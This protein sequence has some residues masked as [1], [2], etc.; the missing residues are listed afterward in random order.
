MNN[1]RATSSDSNRSSDSFSRSKEENVQAYVQE[2]RREVEAKFSASKVNNAYTFPRK[3]RGHP[4]KSESKGSFDSL[5]NVAFYDLESQNVKHN[6]VDRTKESHE[7]D[8]DVLVEVVKALGKLDSRYLRSQFYNSRSTLFRI[9]RQSVER[10]YNADRRSIDTKLSGSRDHHSPS[11]DET[12][13]AAIGGNGPV[14]FE[15]R[16]FQDP[17]PPR[18]MTRNFSQQ[19]L[20]NSRLLN[21]STAPLSPNN[22]NLSCGSRA[23]LKIRPESTGTTKMEK[24]N[25]LVKNAP[26]TATLGSASKNL[27]RNYTNHS[28]AKPKSP[29]PLAPTHR[30]QPSITSKT[31]TVGSARRDFDLRIPAHIAPNKRTDSREVPP[32]KTMKKPTPS[33]QT[34]A[35]TTHQGNQRKETFKH[36]LASQKKNNFS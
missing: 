15:T 2:F 35:F 17:V 25:F 31:Q 16:G 20:I 10:K 23:A 28:L 33:L 27:S 29:H 12:V 22:S 30:P 11:I 13:K 32:R 5:E 9:L 14:P 21:T 19:R 6:L 34:F 4:R 18:P 3:A 24:V 36:F 26:S 8:A 1:E 7:S